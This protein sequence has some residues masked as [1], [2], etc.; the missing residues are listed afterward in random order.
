MRREFLPLLIGDLRDY[1]AI[2]AHVALGSSESPRAVVRVATR[3]AKLQIHRH[4]CMR[5]VVVR[6]KAA[7]YHLGE[8]SNL[9][10]PPLLGETVTRSALG[11]LLLENERKRVHSRSLSHIE[12]SP[13]FYSTVRLKCPSLSQNSYFTTITIENPILIT[14][15]N[16]LYRN[17]NTM[18]LFLI[19]T[20]MEISQTFPNIT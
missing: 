18:V 10:T 19:G 20:Y 13:D 14:N 12:I 5:T 3:S 15:M 11:S 9:F 16:S 1:F 17:E 6:S 4:E 8:R 2:T 7:P